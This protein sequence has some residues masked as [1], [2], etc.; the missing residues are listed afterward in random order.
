MMVSNRTVPSSRFFDLQL[1]ITFLKIFDSA[2]LRALRQ[3][4]PRRRLLLRSWFILKVD[5]DFFFLLRK[6]V[7]SNHREERNFT[8]ILTSHFPANSSRFLR[9]VKQPHVSLQLLT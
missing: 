8:G 6:N 1:R 2:P 9:C 5:R 4:F 7:L 3:R